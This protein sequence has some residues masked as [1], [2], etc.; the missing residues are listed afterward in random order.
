MA[1][2]QYISPIRLL[3]HLGIDY[4]SELN[5]PRIKKHLAAEFSVARDGF[6]EIDGHSY[7]KNDVMEETSHPDF[8]KR[9]V[10]HHRIWKKPALLNLLEDNKVNVPGVINDLDSFQNDPEFDEF[11][12]PYFAAPFNYT[13][14]NL[15]GDHNLFQL[16]DWLSVEGFVLAPQKETALKSIRIFL[17]ENARIFRNLNQDNYGAFRS[18]LLQWFRFGWHR[19]FNNLPEDFHAV[20]ED[21]VVNL[22]NHSVR[23]QKSNREDCQNISNELMQL[24][25]LPDNIRNTIESNDKVYNARFGTSSSSTSSGS[26]SYWWVIWVVIA[27]LRLATNGGCN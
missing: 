17:E 19:F 4:T 16:G 27:L 15:I 25:G 14:R 13:A 18:K 2:K 21:M 5:I 7:N 22:I 3:D 20:K 6:I 12:S 10:F 11:F 1:E 24:H 8:P 26:G 23:I 9:L